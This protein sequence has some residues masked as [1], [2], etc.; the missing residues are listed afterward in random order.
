MAGSV[1]ME[2]LSVAVVPGETGVCTV[3]IRNT[4]SVVDQFTP[5]VL[6]QPAAWTTVIPA[7][8]SLFPGADGTVDLHFAPP[9]ATGVGSGPTPFGVRVVGS[10][11]PDNPVVEEGEV[12]LLGYVDVTAKLTP[13]S[14]EAKRKSRHE[15]IVDNKGNRPVAVQLSVIDPDEQLA[16]ALGDSS[17]TVDA[18]QSAHVPLKVAARKGFARGTDKHRPFQVKA[19]PEGASY[20]LTMDGNLIQKPGMP[21]FILPLIA[22]AVALVLIAALA[23]ALLKKGD[24]SASQIGADPTTTTAAPVVVTEPPANPDEGPATPEEAKAAA[25]A[26]L[27]ANGKDP[28]AA[29][30]GGTGAAGSGT[31]PAGGETTATT[32][33]PSEESTDVTS[34]SA[35]TAPPPAAYKRFLG[36]WNNSATGR[37]VAQIVLKSDDKII[38]LTATGGRSG[39]TP[40]ADA[41]DGEITYT[42]TTPAEKHV[43]KL[44][45]DGTVLTVTVTPNDADAYTDT[46]KKA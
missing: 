1:M 13:R 27:A 16:F 6:G 24:S 19:V 14:V 21:R 41:D 15:I 46:F 30:A 45:A 35:T 28:G 7:M 3:R 9:R 33:A 11:D 29:A 26:E 25:A 22:G 44:N 43:M 31:A 34:P 32:A 4:G 10:Q 37:P 38:A 18:G 12:D 40:V 36:T 42:F 23:P 20:P 17:V 8:I 2:Q 5:T 39:T